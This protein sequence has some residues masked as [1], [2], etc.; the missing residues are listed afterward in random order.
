MANKAQNTIWQQV[1][2]NGPVEPQG[3]DWEMKNR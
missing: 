2:G 1:S 3:S